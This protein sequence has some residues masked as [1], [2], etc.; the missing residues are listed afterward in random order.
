MIEPSL[1]NLFERMQIGSS[2]KK[3]VQDKYGIN[4][5][6]ELI[7]KRFQLY[8]ATKKD[9]IFHGSRLI[10]A[11]NFIMTRKKAQTQIPLDQIITSSKSLSDSFEYFIACTALAN[12][13]AKRKTKLEKAQSATGKPKD[14]DKNKKETIRLVSDDDD[15]KIDPGSNNESESDFDDGDP[16][17][18]RCTLGL[19]REDSTWYLDVTD[20]M[21][22]LKAWPA[23]MRVPVA[24]FQ[25]IYA[26]QRSGLEWLSGLAK[27]G[28]GGILGE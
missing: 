14:K 15:W 5:L 21:I 13:L 17:L 10:S 22:V 27:E 12:I 24:L 28:T 6:Q 7:K 11:I 4:S 8:R 26:H 9:R 2:D 23:A 19:N 25:K 1:A 16:E 18:L 3:V 20:R